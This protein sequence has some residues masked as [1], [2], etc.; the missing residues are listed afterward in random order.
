MDN[1][2]NCKKSQHRY[3]GSSERRLP[4]SIAGHLRGTSPSEHSLNCRT[5]I[6]VILATAPWSTENIAKESNKTKKTLMPSQ[7]LHLTNPSFL[8]PC[9]LTD[10]ELYR[11]FSRLTWPSFSDLSLSLSLRKLRLATA[12]PCTPGLYAETQDLRHD[13]SYSPHPPY[14]MPHSIFCIVHIEDSMVIWNG[15][16]LPRCHMWRHL[17]KSNAIATSQNRL[18]SSSN[19]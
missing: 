4:L 1:A 15:H 18:S 14:L 11:H 12:W 3:I 13:S 6:N 2:K 8:P 7:V 10:H 17:E 9:G 16:E 5:D 19:T